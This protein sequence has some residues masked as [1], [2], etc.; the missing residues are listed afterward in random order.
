MYGGVLLA[1]ATAT[2]V[3]RDRYIP[4]SGAIYRRGHFPDA[5]RARRAVGYVGDAGHTDRLVPFHC[6]TARVTKP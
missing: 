2:Y 5:V 6:G 1:T 3:Y 4:R